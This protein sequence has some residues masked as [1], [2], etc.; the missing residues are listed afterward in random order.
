MPET[1]QNMAKWPRREWV[2]IWLLKLYFS[3]SKL[4]IQR[5]AV[6]ISL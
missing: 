2:P 4:P 3:T 6:C 1:E 5:N